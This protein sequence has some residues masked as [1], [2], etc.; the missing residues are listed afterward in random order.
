VA[1]QEWVSPEF[2]WEADFAH[3]R[4]EIERAS[5]RAASAVLGALSS[6]GHMADLCQRV[7]A[8]EAT[9]QANPDHVSDWL[10]FLEIVSN[11]AE[12]LYS[13]NTGMLSRDREIDLLK[14]LHGI[15]ENSLDAQVRI[16][17]L[18]SS[19]EARKEI[20]VYLRNLMKN[21]QGAVSILGSSQGGEVVGIST[22]D[23]RDAS[24]TT[25]PPEVILVSLIGN[26]AAGIPNAAD[27]V[28]EDILPL[29]RRLVG[30]GDLFM[31]RVYGQSMIGA[32]IME[33]DLVVIRQQQDANNGEIVVALIDGE[34]TIKTYKKTGR[35]ISLLPQS[36]GLKGIPD[37]IPGEHARIMGKLV[38]V[39]RKI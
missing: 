23:S 7:I 18:P 28:V 19:P 4:A 34:A 38:A 14:F 27:Q 24:E 17:S 15:V 1:R 30:E 32:G 36:P 10:D 22:P 8:R 35:K 26:I 33:G 5:P 20:V 21:L 29:P 39:L 37:E 12:F 2:D 13:E 11:D 31:L 3:A 9:W 6:A 25:E 16:S